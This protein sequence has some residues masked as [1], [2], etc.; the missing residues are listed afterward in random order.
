MQDHYINI[1]GYCNILCSEKQIEEEGAFVLKLSLITF[2][3]SIGKTPCY[4]QIDKGLPYWKT[5]IA[6]LNEMSA[7]LE[8]IHPLEIGTFYL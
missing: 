5:L 8:F 6:R 3:V 1:L 2:N 4:L 7:L